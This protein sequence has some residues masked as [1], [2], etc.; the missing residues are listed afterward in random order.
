MDV[1]R[2]KT[3]S[4]E[5]RV[6]NGPTLENEIVHR[7]ERDRTDWRG[8]NFGRWRAQNLVSGY[9]AEAENPKEP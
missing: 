4:G 8:W 6:H 7:W 3:R 2:T 9:L 1:H 5:V